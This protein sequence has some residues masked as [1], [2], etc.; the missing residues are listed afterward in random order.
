M[1]VFLEIS[2]VAL[3]FYIGLLKVSPL[4]PAIPIS[5]YM[6]TVQLMKDRDRQE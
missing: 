5:H 3:Y 6:P 4:D 2:I 1:I